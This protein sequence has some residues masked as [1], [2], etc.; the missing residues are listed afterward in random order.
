[1]IRSGTLYDITSKTN[2]F[3]LKITQLLKDYD[4]TPFGKCILAAINL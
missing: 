2:M 4:F 3:G 1:M